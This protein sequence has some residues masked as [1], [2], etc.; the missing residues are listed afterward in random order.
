LSIRRHLLPYLVLVLM[1][2]GCADQSAKFSSDRRIEELESASTDAANNLTTT[3]LEHFGTP[4]RLV[5]WSALPIDYGTVSGTVLSA[6]GDQLRLS[7]ETKP[8]AGLANVAVVFGENNPGPRLAVSYDSD[9]RMLTLAPGTKSDTLPPPGTRVRLI[10]HRLQQGRQSF[11][12]HCMHC[13]GVAGDGFGPTARYIRNHKFNPMPRDFRRGLFKF[14]STKDGIYASRD[15]LKRTVKLGLSGTYMPSFLLLSDAELDAVV[16]YV[17]FLAIR[18]ETER[19]LLAHF[20]PLIDAKTPQDRQPLE[21]ELNGAGFTEAFNDAVSLV[22]ENWQA[23]EESDNVV[24]PTVARVPDGFESRKKGRDLFIG[25]KINCAKCHG[26]R[27]RG[28]GS[29]LNEIQENPETKQ[30]YSEPGLFDNWE[31]KVSPRDL[32]AGIYRGGRRPLDLFR[33]VTTGVK[34]TP[35]PGFAALKEEDRWHIVNYILSIPIAGVFPEK[36]H[37]HPD[38]DDHK[39]DKPAS[40]PT[41]STKGS[42]SPSKDK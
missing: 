4:N 39:A 35:M 21:Q 11:M 41:K 38:G 20:Q 27:G 26:P 17:R 23:A 15:D 13:H 3:L 9:S 22:A 7:L 2:A 31:N 37:D 8:P 32:T 29:F 16:E 30:K 14:T 42:G 12:Q 36:K 6:S 34:G 33:R 28:N 19:R 25:T 10:G 24:L 1:V 40:A 5:S 18:G